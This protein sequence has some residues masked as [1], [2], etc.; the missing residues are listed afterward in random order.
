MR[1]LSRLTMI[2]CR[3]PDTVSSTPEEQ[4]KRSFLDSAPGGNLLQH[5]A[6]DKV[7]ERQH[8]VPIGA[9]QQPQGIE[10]RR[11]ANNGS[12]G[13]A[14]HFELEAGAAGELHLRDEAQELIGLDRLHA[15]TIH[16]IT[17]TKRIWIAATASHS[18]SS[19]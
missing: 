13:I 14:S 15:P 17:N 19:D 12:G 9:P 11:L 7:V 8:G 16:N 4:N 2:A 6:E 1:S 18:Y 3:L 5:A 10:V